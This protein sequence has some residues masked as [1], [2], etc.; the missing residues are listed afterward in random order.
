MPPGSLPT[1]LANPGGA[2]F[3]GLKM[4][5]SRKNLRKAIA[6]ADALDS[7]IE[8][9]EGLEPD[10]EMFLEHASDYINM[11]LCRMQIEAG[12]DAKAREPE[13]QLRLPM[14]SVDHATGELVSAEERV[15]S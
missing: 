1:A 14:F 2:H 4:S 11:A 15:E 7:L 10:V 5:Y 13:I 8:S 6:I 9:K 3:G 12:D